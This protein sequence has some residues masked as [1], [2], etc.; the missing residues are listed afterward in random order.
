MNQTENT[1]LANFF[2]NGHSVHFSKGEIILAGDDQD[3][4]IHYLSKGF[5]KIYSINDQGEE[6]VHIIY[7]AGDIFPFIWALKD[8][9]RRVFYEALSSSVLWKIP[10]TDFLNY[11]KANTSPVSF[12]LTKQLAEQFNIYADRLDNLEYRSAYERVVHRLLFLAGRFG[13]KEPGGIVITAPITHK[14][15]AQSINLARE[16]VSREMEKLVSKGLIKTIDGH[17]VLID[18]EKLSKEF[19]EPVSLDYWGLQEHNHEW[20]ELA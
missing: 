20:P 9:R 17:I 1:T 18:V 14:I 4:D 15:I 19:S 10:K 2:M 8:I 16:S 11:L 7:K 3:P 12:S 13:K 6:Y 5:V